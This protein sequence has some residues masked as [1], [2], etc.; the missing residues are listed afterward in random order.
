MH[1]VREAVYDRASFSFG[2]DD[3]DDDDDGM[4]CIIFVIA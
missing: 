3:D 2:N 4:Y 1:V